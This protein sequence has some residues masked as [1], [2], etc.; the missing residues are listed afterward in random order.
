MRDV[1]RRLESLEARSG[2]SHAVGGD[3]SDSALCRFLAKLDP[4]SLRACLA[5]FTDQ[6]FAELPEDIRVHVP[7]YGLESTECGAPGDEWNNW[8]REPREVARCCCLGPA[9]PTE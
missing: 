7:G 8:R 5:R 6:Q 4:A 1:I 3:S 9:G 2:E